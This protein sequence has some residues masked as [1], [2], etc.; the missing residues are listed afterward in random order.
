[1]LGEEELMSGTVRIKQLGLGEQSK[2]EEVERGKMVEAAVN[3]LRKLD[4]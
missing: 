3:L 1:M 4:A 2:G